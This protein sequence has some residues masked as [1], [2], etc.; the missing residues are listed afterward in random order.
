MA[1]AVVATASTVEAA[2]ASG[3]AYASGLTPAQLAQFD[4][5]GYLILPD[6][7]SVASASALKSHVDQLVSG[8]DLSTH[9][10]T[11][12]RAGASGSQT[13]GNA[14]DKNRYFLDSADKV[15]YFF[16]EQAWK[17][18]GTLAVPLG[19]AI[20]KIGHY[21]HVLDAPFAA[22]TNRPETKQLAKSLGFKEPVV[23]QS[24][25]SQGGMQAEGE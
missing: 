9:P 20:N 25:V 4:R 14:E 22:F 24:M 23:L 11:V 17:A 8:I 12:F 1:S 19:E 21:L 5:D 2:G 15:S 3:S 18:D 10:K 13:E 7:F 16:E 6:F